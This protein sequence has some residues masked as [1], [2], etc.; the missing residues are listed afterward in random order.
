MNVLIMN[1]V[2]HGDCLG[3]GGRKVEILDV[4]D[5]IRRAEAE[6]QNERVERE[7]RIGRRSKTRSV[8]NQRSE[9]HA[10]RLS[11][12]SKYSYLI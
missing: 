5:R 7:S 10:N 9:I 2:F 11:R 3:E 6:E 12:I 8:P 4:S 1:D